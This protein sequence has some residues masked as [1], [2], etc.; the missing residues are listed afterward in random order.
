MDKNNN[1]HIKDKLPLHIANKD[2][3]NNIEK[4]IDGAQKL[5]DKLPVHEANAQLWNKIEP[6]IKLR[7]IQWY[8]PTGIAAA[9]LAAIFAIATLLQSEKET[10]DYQVENGVIQTIPGNTSH[11]ERGKQFD[12]YCQT[13][14]DVCET[15]K[16]STLKNQLDQI[17]QQ[18]AKLLEMQNYDS[19]PDNALYIARINKEVSSIELKLLALF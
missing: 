11:N 10:I 4:G 13:F 1:I 2:L 14:P 18:R 15:D 17:V 3:W 12:Q 6:K 5:S 19:D 7:K 8:A 16:Y 9:L